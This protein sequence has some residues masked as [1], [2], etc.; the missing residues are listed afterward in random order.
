MDDAT[1]P[2][3][4]DALPHG[5]QAAH[6]L[7]SILRH[8]RTW[9]READEAHAK[10]LHEVDDEILRL[11]EAIENLQRELTALS[12]FRDDLANKRRSLAREQSQRAHE[13]IFEVLGR[14]STALEE[15]ATLATEAEASRAALIQERINAS[16]KAAAIAEYKKFEADLPALDALPASYRD[17]LKAHHQAQGEQLR[18]F[19]QQLDPGLSQLDAPPLALDV[20]YTVD[21]IEGE[22]EL[23][24]IVMPIDET[25]HSAWRDRPED[26][27]LVVAARVVQA[28]YET[29]HAL[30]LS[31]S[32]AMYGGHR[33]LLAV[34]LE[35]PRGHEQDLAGLVQASIDQVL[36]T[37][38]ELAAA[39]ITARAA[40]VPVDFLLPPAE[41]SEETD[42]VE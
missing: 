41:T 37:A 12:S 42:D 33:G 15:R 35:F 38:P 28:V 5:E 29:A 18:A 40:L 1:N 2:G 19:I 25:V 3:A 17:V 22:P 13:R 30:G 16:D 20:V 36:S 8:V 24:S 7:G 27:Q 6:D 14:Q 23:V 39:K 11:R 4:D 31:R 9:R 10:Q 34:E 21:Q 26:L 32:H